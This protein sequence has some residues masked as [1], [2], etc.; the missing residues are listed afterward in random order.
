MTVKTITKYPAIIDGERGTYGVVIPDLE[1]CGMGATV[2]EVLADAAQALPEYLAVLREHGQKI[3][4]P[5][6]LDEISLAEGEM[7]AYV[8]LGE[9]AEH[10]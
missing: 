9:Q 5:S 2:D 10:N 8:I 4:S 1:A 3:P 6:A 7:L